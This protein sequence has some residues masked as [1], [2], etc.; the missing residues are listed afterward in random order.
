MKNL[1]A[2][3]LAALT[4]GL[5]QPAVAD[6]VKIGFITTLSGSGSGIGTEVRDG[7]LL[8]IKLAGND[9]IEVLIEDD[10]M[11]PDVAVQI[12]DKMIQSD[13]V[14]ILTGIL[15]SNLVLA[16]A[17]G[18]VA[19]D[20]FYLS[21]NAGPSALAG[22]RCHENFFN[23]SMQTD[24]LAEAMGAHANEAGYKKVFLLAPNYPAGVD[25]MNGFKRFYKGEL[26][27]ELFSKLG[28]TDYAVEISQIRATG[29]DAVFFFLPGGM[30]IA[31]VKQYAQA[32]SDIPLL[33]PGWSFSQDILPAIG[34]AAL[35]AKN[36]AQWSPDFDNPASKAF[37]AAFEAEYGRA[38]S[39]F[40]ATGYD[41]ANLIVSAVGQASVKDADAF[42]AALEAADFD[43]VRGK[44]SFGINHH[45]IQDIY[46][47]EVV[48]QGDVLTNRTIGVV[49]KDHQDAYVSECRM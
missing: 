5:C 25:T 37:V 34:D 23:V 40:A 42:R 20:K 36:T 35:G 18:A 43:S 48:R 45:P 17:P 15:W 21:P 1:L 16:V 47:R 38:P 49:M 41:T 12:A 4:A 11:R 2:V 24:A 28:Q 46:L 29:A 9:E 19:Q 13:E 14:D 27:G 7:F 30:G 8:G 10:A 26:A 32:G 33:G 31:F 3:G 39:L 44:F 22:K 6:P